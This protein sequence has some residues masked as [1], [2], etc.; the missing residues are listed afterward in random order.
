[1][2]DGFTM[3]V[4][5]EAGGLRVKASA[6]V[7]VRP[8][9]IVMAHTRREYARAFRDIGRYS[10]FRASGDSVITEYA[11]RVGFF[12]FPMAVNKRVVRL[13]PGQV[14]IDFWTPPGS[15]ASFD[16]RWTVRALPDGKGSAVHLEQT[17]D[18]PAW[19]RFLPV[20]GAVRGRIERAFEDTAALSSVAPGV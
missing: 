6:S 16:G 12:R 3:D 4:R 20:E 10:R 5:R 17:L 13:A 7:P 8:E 15:T 1:M 18:V 2:A 14:A 9:T 19:A 11:S